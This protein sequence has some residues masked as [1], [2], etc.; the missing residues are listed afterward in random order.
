MPGGDKS[1]EVQVLVPVLLLS[2]S[3]G[4]S[5]HQPV[6]EKG[7]IATQRG[8]TGWLTTEGL[9]RVSSAAGLPAWEAQEARDSLNG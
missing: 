8:R 6:H 7:Q 2:T 5:V 4:P 3:L 9:T 1:P